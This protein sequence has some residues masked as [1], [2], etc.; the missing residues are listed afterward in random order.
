[1]ASKFGSAVTVEDSVE[2][3]APTVSKF[4]ASSIIQDDQAP[5]LRSI[6]P[7]DIIGQGEAALAIG[8][9]IIAEPVSGLAGIAAAKFGFDPAV[10][11]KIISDVQKGLTF[12]PRT[13]SGRQQIKDLAEFI[14]PFAEKLKAAEETLGSAGFEIGELIPI[15]GAPEV[16]GAAGETIPT[17]IGE[18]LGVAG[19]KGAA[20]GIKTAGEAILPAIKELPQRPLFTSGGRAKQRTGQLIEEGSADIETAK[21]KIPDKPGGD[22]GVFGT[23][24]EKLRIGTPEV[25]KDPIATESIKQG[26]DEGVIAAVKASSPTDKAKMTKM[27]E[28]MEQGKK[29]ARFAQTNRPTDVVGDSLM[30]RVNVIQG[31]NKQAGAEIDRASKALEGKPID[32]S[33]AVEGFAQNLDELGVQLIS[34]GKGGFK[35]DFE[36]SVLSP[37][38]RAP[39]KEVIRQMNIRGATG[40]PDGLSAHKMKK[41][42]DNNVTFGKTKTGISGDAERALKS[43]RAGLDDALD[44]TFPDY[45][46]ANVAYSE[47]IGALDALQDVAGKKLD[48]TGPSAS[49]ATGQLLRRVMSNAQSRVNLVDALDEIE[50]VATKFKNQRIGEGGELLLEGPITTSARGFKDDLLSQVLFADELDKVFKPVARTSFEGLVGRSVERGLGAAA[51]PTGVGDIAISAAAKAADKARGINEANAF[52]SI[53]DLLKEIGIE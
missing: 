33:V 10:T 28:V 20:T 18:A 23:L 39:I 40:D 2:G 34:D 49:K 36:L 15:E 45:N 29:N 38:D 37:G 1:M 50:G 52:K 17:A 42:I 6:G 47:T 14:Q 11:S 35:P 13:A 26:F 24:A 12:E 41:I 5:G 8:S 7:S 44:A 43:F 46:N 25:V 32:L 21:F 19:L 4:G 51:S 9:G 27:V 16:L 22:K 53:K 30:E 48:L 3:A 31:A